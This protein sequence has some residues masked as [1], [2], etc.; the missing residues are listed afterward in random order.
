MESY[1]KSQG[2]E[3]VSL[4]A[5]DVPHPSVIDRHLPRTVRV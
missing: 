2:T 3:A 5:P 1:S 4:R